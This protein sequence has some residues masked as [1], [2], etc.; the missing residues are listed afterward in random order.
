MPNASA[1][2]NEQVVEE[3]LSDARDAR[4][5]SLVDRIDTLVENGIVANAGGKQ[6]KDCL[7][8]NGALHLL[9][10]RLHTDGFFIMLIEKFA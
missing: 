4:Q 5:I 2:E 3:V 7:T 9:P 6:L 8:H 10:G 1:Q